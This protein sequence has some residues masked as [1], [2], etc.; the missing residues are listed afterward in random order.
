MIIAILTEIEYRLV[1]NK[2]PPYITTPKI[3]S[4]SNIQLVAE[5][6]EWYNADVSHRHKN[7]NA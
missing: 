1:K 5:G 4:L 6:A 3:L 2:Y 7:R